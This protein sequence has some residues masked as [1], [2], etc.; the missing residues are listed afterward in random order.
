MYGTVCNKDITC[1]KSD[2]N[3]RCVV[4]D[5]ACELPVALDAFGAGFSCASYS[6][7]NKDAA[8]NATAMDRSTR[9][10]DQEPDAFRLM[11]D[12]CVGGIR[13]T[14]QFLINVKI[15]IVIICT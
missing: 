10:A 7:L 2:E 6:A 3:R 9:Q 13:Y 8:K 15:N 1:L 12:G 14:V 5:A 4:H 11:I